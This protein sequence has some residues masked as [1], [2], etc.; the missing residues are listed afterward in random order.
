MNMASSGLSPGDPGQED[1]TAAL[2]DLERG[3]SLGLDMAGSVGAL[4]DWGTGGEWATDLPLLEGPG[5]SLPHPS[6]PCSKF[7]SQ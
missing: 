6:F 1:I 2:D 7:A 5:C 4:A 3:Q